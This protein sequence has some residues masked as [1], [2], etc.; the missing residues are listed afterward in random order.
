M[1]QILAASASSSAQSSLLTSIDPPVV[2]VEQPEGSSAFVFICDHADRHIPSA[3]GTLGVSETEL[4]NHVAWDIGAGSVARHLAQRLDATVVL[5]NYS[6]LVIDCNRAPDA[7]DSIP[8]RTDWLAVTGNEG[9]DAG[10]IAAREAAVFAP[11][12]DEIRQILDARVRAKRRTLLVS[13]SS[14]T[15]SYRG[16]ARPWMIGVRYGDDAQM[17]G[18]VLKLLRRDERLLIGDNEPAAEEAGVD[19]SLPLHGE[20]RG[21]AHVGLQIRQDQILD[22]AG[23]K[24]WAGRLASL[25]KQAD[26]LLTDA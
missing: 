10:Q 9:L 14:F 4:G 13:I 12:H 25:L 21:I 6:R 1:T 20:A 19:Y 15:P 22:A 24:T 11:Y 3:L 26:A 7:A 23:Q 17:A 8:T 16:D 5:Q 2:S 18:V